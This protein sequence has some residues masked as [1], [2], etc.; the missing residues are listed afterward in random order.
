M[1]AGIENEVKSYVDST[2]EADSVSFPEIADA[3]CQ[4]AKGGGD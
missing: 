2:R 3:V 1:C 4:Q